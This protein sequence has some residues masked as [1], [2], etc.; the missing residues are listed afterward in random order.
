MSQTIKENFK[1]ARRIYKK[2][3]VLNPDSVVAQEGLRLLDINSK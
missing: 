2:V 1:E 3:L